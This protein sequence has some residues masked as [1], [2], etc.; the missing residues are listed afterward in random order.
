MKP[1]SQGSSNASPW[2]VKTVGCCQNPNLTSTQQLGFTWKW[3]CTTTTTTT[4]TQCQQYLICYWPD[5]D[6]TLKVGSW[7]H[8]EQILSRWHLSRQHLSWQQLSILGIFQLYWPNLDQI[9]KVGSWEHLD[10]IKTVTVTLVKATF[11]LVT[12]VNIRKISAVS[13]LILTKL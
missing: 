8:L 6:K 4:E 3:L 5:F 13:D 9:L 12:F 11:V 7:T 1:I 2:L 10:Q